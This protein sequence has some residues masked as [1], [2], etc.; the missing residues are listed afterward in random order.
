MACHSLC[1]PPTGSVLLMLR[2]RIAHPSDA[3]TS[4]YDYGVRPDDHFRYGQTTL[5]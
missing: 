2:H 4:G 3:V 1:H 5:V